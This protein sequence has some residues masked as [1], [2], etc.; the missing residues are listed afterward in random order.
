MSG[1]LVNC[2]DRHVLVS[3][4]F[5]RTRCWDGAY[6]L[7]IRYDMEKVTAFGVIRAEQSVPYAEVVKAGQEVMDGQMFSQLS[8]T[9]HAEEMSRAVEAGATLLFGEKAA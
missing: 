1:L 2:A 9:I 7:R 3:L 5:G 4:N 8:A 6:Q